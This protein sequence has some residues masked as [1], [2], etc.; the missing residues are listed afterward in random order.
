MTD[1]TV[2]LNNILSINLGT[3]LAN[4]QVKEYTSLID[5]LSEWA[6]SPSIKDRPL[7]DL[8]STQI[9]YNFEAGRSN[10]ESLHGYIIEMCE[11][12]SPEEFMNNFIGEQ[13]NKLKLDL[14]SRSIKDK[15]YYRKF[16]QAAIKQNN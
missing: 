2:K 7:I 16:I 15:F 12:K 3:L 11:S 1:Q 5:A 4:Y 8:I 14:E 10:T 6:C 13:W 9:V